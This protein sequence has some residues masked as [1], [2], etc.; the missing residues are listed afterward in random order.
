MRSPIAM[1]TIFLDTE[2][3]GL[4]GC[5]AGGSDEIVEL[6]ILD[7]RGKPLVDQLVR[8]S[9]RKSWPEAQRIHG[10]SPSMVAG[11]PTLDAL[12]PEIAELIRDCLVVIYNAAFDLQFFP[13][14]L[15]ASSRVECAM[16]RYAE[17]KGDWNPRYGNPRWHKLHVAA[18]A[19]GFDADV[20]WHRALCDTL[21]CRHVWRYL[22]RCG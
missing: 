19:T 9:R 6:A 21:A 16:L 1:K 22:E 12:L 14:E 20:Q 10:I 18:H 11:A 5:Y 15:F 4:R 3:T 13:A 2:T 8:P 17:W 7:N